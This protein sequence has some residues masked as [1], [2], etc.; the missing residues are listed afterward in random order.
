MRRIKPTCDKCLE[1]D[2]CEIGARNKPACKD[3][4]NDPFKL[5]RREARFTFRVRGNEPAA[6]ERE[7]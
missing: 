1:L 5:A 7:T 3:Y 6:K 2:R 4:M